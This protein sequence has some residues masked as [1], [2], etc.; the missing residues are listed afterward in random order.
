MIEFSPEIELRQEQK[1]RSP[2][3]ET[4]RK[5]KTPWLNVAIGRL[6]EPTKLGV[7]EKPLICQGFFN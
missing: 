7:N 1:S 6:R 4:L 3:L 5:Q 2:T